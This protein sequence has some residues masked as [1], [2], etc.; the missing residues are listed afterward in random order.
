MLV[1]YLT[2]SVIFTQ[3]DALSLFFYSFTGYF[4]HNDVHKMER[5]LRST[6]RVNYKLLHDVGKLEKS[7][8]RFEASSGGLSVSLNEDLPFSVGVFSPVAQMSD[9]EMENATGNDDLSLLLTEL[10]S[11]KK[12]KEEF[13]A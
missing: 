8:S 5:N 4:N 11:V 7:S 6:E 3:F 1:V 12:E 13:Q 2:L 9:K 10:E